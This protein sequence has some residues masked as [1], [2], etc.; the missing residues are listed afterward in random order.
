MAEQRITD[1]TVKEFKRDVVLA[2]PG[3]VTTQEKRIARSIPNEIF[4]DALRVVFNGDL[5]LAKDVLYNRLE[6]MDDSEPEREIDRLSTI[7]PAAHHLA[8]AVM[9][10]E[11]ILVI[12]DVDNDGDL[13]QAIAMEMRNISGAPM[14]AE[15]REYEPG[16]HGFDLA[17]IEQWL[18]QKDLAPNDRFT[19]MVADLGTNQRSEQTDFLARYP[20][21]HLIIADHH[22][23]DVD[24][25]VETDAGRSWLVSPFI[26]GGAR[27]AMRNAGGVSGSFLLY[28]IFKRCLSELRERGT[29][30]L[31]DVAMKTRIGPMRAMAKAGNMLDFVS[32][33]VRLKP[34]HEVD[35]KRASDL[36][37]LTSNGR[38]IGRWLNPRQVVNIK[39][40]SGVV[41]DEAVGELLSFR[42]E[43]RKA[44]H[45]AGALRNVLGDVVHGDGKM[46]VANAVAISLDA[47]PVESS[48]GVNYV[49]QL[50]AYLFNFNY[51]NQLPT[52][53]KNAWLSLAEKCFRDV[54]KTERKIL[55]ALRRYDLI[56]E[57]S[58]DNVLITRPISRAVGAAFSSRMLSKAYHSLSKPVSLSVTFSGDNEIALRS[59]SEVSMTECLK[60]LT[61][62]LPVDD[63]VYRGHSK[64]GALVVKGFRG[65]SPES[66]LMTMAA[67]LTHEAQHILDNTEVRRAL[68]VT[69]THLPLMSE[70]LTK[71]RVHTEQ[72]ASPTLL[73]RISE[74]TIFE[75]KYTV[76][77]LTVSDLVKRREWEVTAEP[78]DFSGKY[79]LILPNQALKSIANDGFKGA[80]GLTLLPSGS[81]MAGKV[82]RARQLAPLNIPQLVVPLERDRQAMAEE[83]TEHFKGKERPVIELDRDTAV[84]AIKFTA[85]GAQVFANTEA[86]LLGVL[87][88]TGADSYVV[89]DVEAD[90]AGNADEI[91]VGLAI[92][93]EKPGSG[94]ILSRDEMKSVI[95]KDPAL[96]RNATPKG[97]GFLVNREVSVSLF[98]QL[99]SRRGGVPIRVSIKTQNLT[100][101]TNELLEEVGEDML[102]VEERM[103]A[104]LD[105]CGTFVVSAHNLP[106]DNNI[107]RVNCPRVYER[108]EEAIHLDS[109]VPSREY[110]I[111]YLNM[112]VN[113]IEKVAYYNALHEGYNLNTLLKS[114]KPYFDFPSVKGTHVIQVRGEDVFV[115]ALSTQVTTKLKETRADLA[116]RLPYQMKAMELPGYSIE[117]LMLVATIHDMISKQPIKEI[118]KAPFDGM[119]HITMSDELWDTFQNNYAYDLSVEQ[120]LVRFA[121]LPDVKELADTSINVEYDSA[122]DALKSARDLGG[123]VIAPAKKRSK[124]DQEAHDAA[125]NR[126]SGMDIIRHN[127]I[128]FLRAN[129]DN[130]ERYAR[131]WV[132]ELVLD[133]YEPTRKTLPDG[134]IKGVAEQTGIDPDIITSIYDEVYTYRT[135]LGK[136]SVREVETHNNVGPDGDVFQESNAFMHMLT[137][138][139]KNP[140]LDGPSAYLQGIDP[141]QGVVDV[142]C[143][144]AASSTLKQVIRSTSFIVMD[145]DKLNNYSAKQLEQ[146]SSAEAGI[147]GTHGTIAKLKS[148]ATGV[149]IEL[150]DFDAASFRTQP[151]TDRQAWES[152][153]EYAAIAVVLANSRN[154]KSVGSDVRPVLEKAYSSPEAMEALSQSAEYFGRMHA[155][156]KD[157][158]L[159]S[160]MKVLCDA[161]VDGKPLKVP[162]NKELSKADLDVVANAARTGIEA[163]RNSQNFPSKVDIS[164]IEE[165]LNTSLGQYL[166]SEQ[167]RA[168]AKEGGGAV[169]EVTGYEPVDSTGKRSLTA[170]KKH[171]DNAIDDMVELNPDLVYSLETTKKEPVD[172]MLKSPLVNG[173][174]ALLP[175]PEIAPQLDKKIR[176]S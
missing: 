48:D 176:R 173:V 99:I 112:Q 124:K 171:I 2:T 51:E 164:A 8:D 76:E 80:L 24:N 130:A 88:K 29:L 25:K 81:Y 159:K 129:P 47:S 17:Q 165:V 105:E 160:I 4:E 102:V 118:N 63:V 68:L 91:N 103:L 152:V 119:G 78:L 82:F 166:A 168:S 169:T 158:R 14:S 40:L 71:M 145:D 75:D 132:Y 138:R 110:A 22:E 37:R 46:N 109:A 149:D 89:V 136:E 100:N 38:D 54:G 12:S 122:D 111:A 121:A 64:S 113:M 83:Y 58:T 73:M 74:D 106:Y 11:N 108:F 107:M 172:F 134:I 70:I 26:K 157:A 7:A 139:L 90:G 167:T 114:D 61:A 151:H 10:G 153:A 1:K 20:N 36:S 3:M 146:Y 101:L 62:D 84:E 98:S 150:P 96:I 174:M 13:A 56:K 34:L 32:C 133:K 28:S 52:S 35:I 126:F 143:R 30:E 131:A 18:Q 104:T 9:A 161:I 42:D 69:P 60:G 86:K 162:F 97:D 125:L 116:E 72:G 93:K 123:K 16:Q 39:A 144:Q 49:E 67:S 21:G 92:Y 44:N 95:Q 65:N 41:G 120:N 77:K 87:D 45:F 43:L 117:K 127:A 142:L 66:L 31:D 19:V 135:A 148:K 156:T 154:Q 23:P 27:M 85:D 59:R 50:G 141:H 33:D 170:I 175:A 115:K 94:R 163:L 140:Y 57:I 137:Q 155:T 6:D 53:V 5:K 128:Q 79:A 15:S 147:V 55:D